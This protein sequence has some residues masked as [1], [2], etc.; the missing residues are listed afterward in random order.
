MSYAQRFSFLLFSDLHKHPDNNFDLTMLHERLIDFLKKEKF[1]CDYI[2]I[3]GDVVN[4]CNHTD[5]SKG[6]MAKLRG[7]VK[8]PEG[9]TQR[10]FWAAGNHDI[11][12][13]KK[14]YREKIIQKIR[15]SNN[16]SDAFEQKM[17]SEESRALLTQIGMAEYLDVYK[18]IC[19]FE[20]PTNKTLGAHRFFA[21]KELNLFVLNTCLTS[22][23]D[24]DIP[25]LLI[26]ENRLYNLFEEARE[27][28]PTIVEAVEKIQS[29]A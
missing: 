11:K 17:E 12:R 19:G 2:F 28:L 10:V 1:S 24:N 29:N 9:N 4:K 13:D 8:L 14:T 22:C 20:F 6:Y 16:P 25:K 18:D 7:A 27:N 26:L 21:L 3:A 5:I 15:R 23:D